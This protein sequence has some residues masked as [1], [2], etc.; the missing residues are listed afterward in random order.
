M[1]K[2]SYPEPGQAPSAICTNCE[3]PSTSENPIVEIGK[4]SDG[5]RSLYSHVKC[6][7]F[8]DKK[9]EMDEL[10]QRESSIWSFTEKFRFLSNDNSTVQETFP[11]VPKKD[12]KVKPITKV[13]AE[14][15]YGADGVPIPP[16]K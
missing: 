5:S 4:S 13:E 12:M 9:R 6:P 14:S 2:H 10:H 1:N 3:M 7:S 15:E 8:R 11:E 16:S